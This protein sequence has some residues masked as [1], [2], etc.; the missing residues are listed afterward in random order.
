[1]TGNATVVLESREAGGPGR[2]PSGA[3]SDENQ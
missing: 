1:M 2:R 3:G